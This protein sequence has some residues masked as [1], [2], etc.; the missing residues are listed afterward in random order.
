MLVALRV[1]ELRRARALSQGILAEVLQA[2]PVQVSQIEHHADMYIS[3]L[4]RFVEAMGGQLDL[5]AR[6]PEASVPIGR[7][8][9]L[10]APE[11][12]PL[13]QSSPRCTPRRSTCTSAPRASD[14]PV[15][16]TRQPRRKKRLGSRKSRD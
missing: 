15:P 5:V 7:F 6:F 2:F 14:R 11:A 10:A 13:L 16:S 3:T 1:T 4:R 12:E 8:A 9:E